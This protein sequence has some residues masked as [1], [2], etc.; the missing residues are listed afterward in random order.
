[1]CPDATIRQRLP[2][3]GSY[4]VL[5]MQKY[6]ILPPAHRDRRVAYPC[7]ARN[8]P[9][10]ETDLLYRPGMTPT[11]EQAR[12]LANA[13]QLEHAA[14]LC[15][16]ILANTPDDSDALHLLGVLRSA[17][18]DPASAIELIRRSIALS[19]GSARHYLNLANALTQQGHADQ[20]ITALQRATALDPELDDAWF[21][22][23]VVLEMQ[24]KRPEAAHQYRQATRV[25]PDHA[26]A[27]HNLSIV[28]RR[29]GQVD[30]AIE[31]GR[32]ALDI[33]PHSAN[34]AYNLG[35]AYEAAGKTEQ[36]ILAFEQAAR[37]DA[38]FPQVYQA[39]GTALAG[40][41]HHQKAI[42]ALAQAAR[43]DPA[44]LEMLG[45]LAYRLESKSHLDA[46][47]LAVD[48]GLALE[49]DDALLRLVA[50]KLER[51]AGR[52]QDAMQKL[53]TV[54][55]RQLEPRLGGAIRHELG[56]LY[57]RLGDNARAFQSFAD[58][59]RL[60]LEVPGNEAEDA[61]AFL[62]FVD[63]WRVDFTRD[64]VQSCRTTGDKPPGN[65]PVFIIGFPRSGTTLLDQIMDSHPALKTIEE[66]PLVNGLMDDV[67]A[68]RSA[69]ETFPQTLARLRTGEIEE[70]RRAY[71]RNAAGYVD[72]QAGE[73][74]VDKLPLNIVRLPLVWRIFPD[75]R[76]VLALRDPRDVCLSC[77]MQFFEVNAAMSNFV[78][79]EG[80]ADTYSRVMGLWLHYRDTLPVKA[81][82]IRYET[83][84][85][86]TQTEI[87]K[88]LDFLELEWDDRLLQF[89][90]HAKARST[91][92][93]P[94][95]HQ[96]TEPIYT[97]AANRWRRY[98]KQL[99]T[100]ESQL[101]PFVKSFEYDA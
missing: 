50:A 73:T 74:L 25:N 32:R 64:W 2:E 68:L 44:S 49:P 75:A 54:D 43:L 22:Y 100:V 61:D 19:G 34:S 94:S 96:V 63:A 13:G 77:F 79:L 15:T 33:N 81:H 9:V 71:F 14:G 4:R 99:A 97:R 3:T 87:R 11:V 28:L 85:S 84:V 78:T 1:M 39:L 41:G 83:L 6:N 93:T 40:Q 101:A 80:T 5:L 21:N 57:D 17:G 47:R 60:Q 92:D 8:T 16:N 82:T 36:A 65:P 55:V 67:N 72:L 30:E 66:K 86:N 95:Y 90:E 58:A 37:Q 76:L 91:I 56:M 52:V 88:L 62:K 70:L 7:V 53:E 23:G 38:S 48:K 45:D 51:R 46:A 26:D 27:W 59:N 42:D 31:S 98:A 18:G 69:S 12:E 29:E 10:P 20:A 89:Y 35:L 24:Q